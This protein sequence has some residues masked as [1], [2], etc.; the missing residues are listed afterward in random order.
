MAVTVPLLPSVPSGDCTELA[1]APH[2]SPSFPQRKL[3]GAEQPLGLLGGPPC[4][5]RSAP[6]HSCTPRALPRRPGK[7]KTSKGSAL[8]HRRKE[9]EGREQMWWISI[10]TES[11]HWLYGCSL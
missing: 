11:A 7:N 9:K 10:I 5:L 6:R 2:T 4:R 3:P 1:A 8:T